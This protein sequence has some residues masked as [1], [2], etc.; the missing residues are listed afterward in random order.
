MQEASK[1]NLC[2]ATKHTLPFVFLS[3]TASNDFHRVE[4]GRVCVTRVSFTHVTL[5]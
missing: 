3:I 5:P 4:M 2:L 1:E